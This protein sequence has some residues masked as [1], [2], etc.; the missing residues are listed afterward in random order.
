[1]ERDILGAV[2]GSTSYKEDYMNEKI[3]QW[4]KEIKLLS[5]IAKIE[6]Q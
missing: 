3:D 1:M 5:E 4:I 6:P 2:I